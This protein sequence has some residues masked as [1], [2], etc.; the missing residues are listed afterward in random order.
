MTN[1]AKIEKMQQ[2]LDQI[3]EDILN[4]DLE[5]DTVSKLNSIQRRIDKIKTQAEDLM[6]ELEV[7][8]FLENGPGITQWK[9]K[10]KKYWPTL[11][12]KLEYPRYDKQNKA[13]QEVAEQQ[14]PNE[15]PQGLQCDDSSKSRW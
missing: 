7:E 5:N 8:D 1:I 2:Q 15:E 11:K 3:D 4:F 6:N 14:E 9:K 12:H 10:K 13:R